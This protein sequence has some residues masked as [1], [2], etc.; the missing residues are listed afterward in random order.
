VFFFQN[1]VITQWFVEWAHTVIVGVNTLG[2]ANTD[3]ERQDALIEQLQIS[4][5]RL[6][7]RLGNQVGND[8]RANAMRVGIDNEA[9]KP[10][11]DPNASLSIRAAVFIQFTL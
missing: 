1:G 3:D 7:C 8:H 4:P 9:I 11:T 10:A 5:Q 6:R 2:A